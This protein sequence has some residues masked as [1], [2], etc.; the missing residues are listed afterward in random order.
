MMVRKLSAWTF[1]ACTAFAQQPVARVS[2]EAASVKPSSQTQGLIVSSRKDNPRRIT[3]ENYSLKDLIR[4][5]WGLRDFQ[6]KGPYWLKS[7]RYNVIATKPLKTTPENERLMMQA[8]LGDRFHLVF[9]TQKKELPGYALLPGKDTAKLIPVAAHETPG[10]RS[11]GTMSDL[12]N[13]LWRQLDRP[14]EN[15][16]GIAGTWY[17]TLAW[18]N[19]A[20]IQPD[21]TVPA[22]PPPSPPPVPRGC[23]AASPGQ[24]PS[25]AP[26]VFAAVKEQMGLRLANAGNLLVELMIIDRAERVPEAN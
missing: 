14:V 3:Y 4:D 2:C 18:S 15:K 25:L 21:G 9:H 1:T 7:E 11:V 24:I 17:F 13:M 23:P 20:A 26:S 19:S 12:A 8:L 5:A 16:T 10:C 6:V 22:P